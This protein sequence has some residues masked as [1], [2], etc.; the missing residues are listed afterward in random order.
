MSLPY[1][2]GLADPGI[3]GLAVAFGVK[4]MLSNVLGTCILVVDRP[5][6]RGDW[7][8]AGDAQGTVE[9][10]GIC[11]TRIRTGDDSLVL[12]PNGKLAAATVNNFGAHRH[13]IATARLLV[14]YG[15]AAG[16]LCRFMDGVSALVADLPYVQP[17]SVQASVTS[18]IPDGIEIE[19]MCLLDMR[20]AAEQ[21]ADKT[22]LML[23][24]QRLAD[25]M[26][27]R[28]NEGDFALSTATKSGTGADPM[29]AGNFARRGTG[30]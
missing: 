14:A 23:G 6:H 17:A 4:E 24:V 1:E 30:I 19:V 2:G 20:S 18:I 9:H 26:R 21:Q 13:R 7:I 11:F 22:A 25:R 29:P 12:V 16:Q 10:I 3:S 27:V 28:L 5:F 15:T 8:E